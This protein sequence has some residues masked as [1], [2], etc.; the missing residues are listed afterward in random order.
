M[1]SLSVKPQTYSLK[2][3]L[4]KHVCVLV[5]KIVSILFCE[6][7]VETET[8]STNS[9]HLE[10]VNVFTNVVMLRF[11]TVLKELGDQNL[12]GDASAHFSIERKVQ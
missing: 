6:L 7:K 9:T 8:L 1:C 5:T 11:S 3:K 4:Q 10:K 12:V 2:K